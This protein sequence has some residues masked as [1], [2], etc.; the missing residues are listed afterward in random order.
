MRVPRRATT[1]AAAALAAVALLLTGCSASP[2]SAATASSG[3]AAKATA[4]K[5]LIV[6]AAASLQGSFDALAKSFQKANPEYSVAPIRYDGSQALATQI[7]NGADVDVIAFADQKS[8]V[9]VT[10]AGLAGK[11]TTFATNTLRIAVAPGDPKGI[12]DLSDLTRPGLKVVICA[13]QVPCGTASQTLLENAGVHLTPASQ[14][15]NVTSVVTRVE[16]DEADAGL[17]YATDIA[18][19]DGKLDGVTPAGAD[20]VV[21]SYPIAV[22]DNAP[23]SRAAHAFVSFVLSSAGQRILAK[24]GFGK[25]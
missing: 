7:V 25:P 21:N 20:K 23:S 6:F 3:A 9:P 13:P 2:G 12:H 10:Q 18:A 8:L 17:V 4:S 16:N 11:G 22:A 5:P 1:A 15:T 24:F 19:S 14:E